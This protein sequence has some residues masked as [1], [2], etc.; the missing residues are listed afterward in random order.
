ML[1]LLYRDV[2]PYNKDELFSN[3]VYTY[4]WQNVWEW[5]LSNRAYKL[6][7]ANYKVISNIYKTVISVNLYKIFL[8]FLQ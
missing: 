4:A 8:Y 6:A 5:G 3:D 1:L 7:N 2:G